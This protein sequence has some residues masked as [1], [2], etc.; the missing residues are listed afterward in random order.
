M[1]SEGSIRVVPR[2][3]AVHSLLNSAPWAASCAQTNMK[4]TAQPAP[5]PKSIF[6][7]Q[8]SLANTPAIS[9]RYS[10]RSKVNQPKVCSPERLKQASEIAL[11]TVVSLISRSA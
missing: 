7:H 8:L 1:L 4:A 5:S 10:T 2:T 9:P 3:S 6:A 11:R